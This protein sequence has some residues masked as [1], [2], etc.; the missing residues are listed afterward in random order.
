MDRDRLNEIISH[1]SGRQVSDSRQ[2]EFDDIVELLMMHKTV[3][4]DANITADENSGEAENS[5]VN[6]EDTVRLIHAVA[7]SCLGS[8]HLW[9]DMKL[10]DRR[11]LS[12]LLETYFKP[13]YDKNYKDMKWKKFFYRQICGWEGFSSCRSPSCEICIDYDEC[14]SPED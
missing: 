14:F 10:Y 4:R 7:V 13:L 3:D 2:D 9:R 12:K 11:E 1:A 8:N 6:D 5:P